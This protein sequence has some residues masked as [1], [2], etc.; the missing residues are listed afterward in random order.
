[1]ATHFTVTPTLIKLKKRQ[2]KS[3][4]PWSSMIKRN[5]KMTKMAQIGQKDVAKVTKMAQ[6][7]QKDVAKVT[8]IAQIGQKDGAKCHKM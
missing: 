6:I 7:G 5:A 8:K 2:F 4:C 1:M 3:A